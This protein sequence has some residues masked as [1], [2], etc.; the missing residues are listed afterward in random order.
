[1]WFLWLFGNNVEDATGRLRFAIFYLLCG[2]IAAFVQVLTNPSSA[3]PM[4]G[5]SGA[6][7]GI[8]GGYLLLFP[9]VRGCS[10]S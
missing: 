2:V 3:I 6:V 10:A 5:A 4:V 8:M 7:S 1:M 9:R